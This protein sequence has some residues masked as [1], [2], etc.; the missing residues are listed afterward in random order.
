MLAL[1][2]R[3]LF[4]C[5]GEENDPRC[6]IKRERREAMFNSGGHKKHVSWGKRPFLVSADE[7]TGACRD[8]VQFVPG[9]RR[10]CINFH[11]SV[12]ADV[13]GIALKQSGV[14]GVFRREA[15]YRFGKCEFHH[16]ALSGVVFAILPVCWQRHLKSSRVS[17][18]EGD[19]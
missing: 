5:L 16:V 13:E 8:D 19:A 18:T 1:R 11:R 14:V 10:L 9:M 6:K 12:D 7:V 3:T 15:R 4:F 2:D 17:V